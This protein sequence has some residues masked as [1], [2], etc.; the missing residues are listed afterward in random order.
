MSDFFCA[1]AYETQS[2]HWQ[3]PGADGMHY[4]YFSIC[5]GIVSGLFDS[6]IQILFIA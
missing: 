5:V 4:Y 6:C 2:L 1:Y 3:V